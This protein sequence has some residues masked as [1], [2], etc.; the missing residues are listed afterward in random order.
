[1]TAC[2]LHAAC[3]FDHANMASSGNDQQQCTKKFANMLGRAAVPP[4]DAVSCNGVYACASSLS[5]ASQHRH[6]HLFMSAKHHGTSRKH[7]RTLANH[8]QHF[9]STFKG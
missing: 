7:L 6:P 2:T 8:L 1:M 3:Y 5:F 4:Y 9:H